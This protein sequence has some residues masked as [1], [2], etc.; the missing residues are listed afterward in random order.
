[1]DVFGFGAMAFLILT[2]KAPATTIADVQEVQQQARRFDPGAVTA[3]LPDS[4]AEVI[5]DLTAVN[6]AERPASV[7][8]ALE[9]VGITW[10]EVRRPDGQASPAEIANPLDAQTGDMI[11]ER[12]L[13]A[14]RRG[15]GS[16]GVA[17]AVPDD[18]A[19]D[20]RELILKVARDDAAGRRLASRRTCSEG[21][22]PR[23][24]RLVET[25]ELGGRSD[26]L[27]SDAGKETLATRPGPR[28]REPGGERRG[29]RQGC[30]ADAR[31]RL[32]S[33]DARRLR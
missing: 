15:E 21:L 9:L 18:E 2:G 17:L 25:L 31:A 3:G 27:M 13:V 10:D 11:G 5:G 16:S 14:G 24:V 32:G 30:A 26:L 20:D 33:D 23:V 7:E 19:D 28:R 8:D 6:E 1:M 22:N 4:L 12:F 29:E